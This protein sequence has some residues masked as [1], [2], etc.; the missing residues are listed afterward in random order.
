VEGSPTSITHQSLS[1]DTREDCRF[2]H[3]G[4]GVMMMMGLYFVDF[5]LKRI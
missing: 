3:D 4:G 5:V 2:G 1:E